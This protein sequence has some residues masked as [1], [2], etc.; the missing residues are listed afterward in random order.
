[1]QQLQKAVVDFEA[2]SLQL[3]ESVDVSDTAQMIM[4]FIRMVFQDFT[5]KKEFLGMVS[6]KSSGTGLNI[7]IYC[8]LHFLT[9]V[10]SFLM[11]IKNDYEQLE[12]E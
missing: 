11:E 6:L 4:I 12:D 2:F 7:G 10:K 5:I 3:D 1:E 8:Y 9:E